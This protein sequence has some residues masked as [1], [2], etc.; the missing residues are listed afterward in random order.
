MKSSRLSEALARLSSNAASSVVARGRIASPGLN[1][2]LLRRL[3]GEP[4]ER[5]SFLADPV[6]EAAL[7]WK[8]ADCTLNDLSGGLLNPELVN[9]LDGAEQERMP[10]DRRPWIHQLSAWQASAEGRSTLVSSG[11][12]SGKTECFMLPILDDLLRSEEKGKLAGIRAILLYP[13]NALIES[14][15]E[16]LA[17]WTKPLKGRVSFALYNGLT[18]E[19][20][21]GE[22]KAR[23]TES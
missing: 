11:T 12:G 15:R 14:Q 9:A 13:L 21:K 5:D 17:A 2:A 20:P 8:S 18:P 7:T 10:R 6:F 1:A 4:G 16:R 3:S 19:T 23:A 22:D